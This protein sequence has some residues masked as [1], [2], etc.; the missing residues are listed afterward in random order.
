MSPG[1]LATS[2]VTYAIAINMSPGKLAMSQVARTTAI[3]IVNAD[4]C[5]SV[6][7]LLSAMTFSVKQ[8][9]GESLLNL[10]CVRT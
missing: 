1:K 8:G 9:L 5:Y 7:Q 10:Q 4:K 6:Y 2:Q 3:K